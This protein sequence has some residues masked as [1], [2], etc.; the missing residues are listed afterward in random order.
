[1]DSIVLHNKY[2]IK[3]HTFFSDY[4]LGTM[5]RLARGLCYLEVPTVADIHVVP[6]GVAAIPLVSDTYPAL[7]EP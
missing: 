6:L 5:S 1:M 2:K 3:K 4:L 7:L